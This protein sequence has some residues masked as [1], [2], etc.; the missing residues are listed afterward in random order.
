MKGVAGQ[1]SPGFRDTFH[2]SEDIDNITATS[3]TEDNDDITD[4]A[5]QDL[6]VAAYYVTDISY[7]TMFSTTISSITFL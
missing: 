2:E 3:E 6:T 5:R 7:K 4:T 1:A